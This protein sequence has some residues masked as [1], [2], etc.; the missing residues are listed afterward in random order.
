LSGA[1]GGAA[2]GSRR[3]AMARLT[4]RRIGWVAKDAFNP[5]DMPTMAAFATE[6][7]IGGSANAVIH[8]SAPTKRVAPDDRG[9]P[10]RDVPSIVTL[11]P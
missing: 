10:R 8:L 2:V 1:A 3:R 9:S 4:G 7:A 11:T 5:S 6:G